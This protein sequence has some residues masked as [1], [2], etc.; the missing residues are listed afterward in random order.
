[1]PTS[2]AL[3]FIRNLFAKSWAIEFLPPF[4]ALQ[5][6]SVSLALGANWVPDRVPTFRA[7]IFAGGPHFHF[8]LDDKYP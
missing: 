4:A 6:L 2:Y 7:E 3:T 1:M 5:E 8:L